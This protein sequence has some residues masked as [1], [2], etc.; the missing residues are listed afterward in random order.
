M[1]KSLTFFDGLNRLRYKYLTK[2]YHKRA[3]NVYKS[4]HQVYFEVHFGLI[5][6][7]ASFCIEEINR[8]SYAIIRNKYFLTLLKKVLKLKN[9]TFALDRNSSIMVESCTFFSGRTFWDFRL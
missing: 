2:F 5:E 4:I 9:S 8:Y 3:E 6:T 7:V 1:G